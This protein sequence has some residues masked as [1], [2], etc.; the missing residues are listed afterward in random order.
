MTTFSL[1][2][3]TKLFPKRASPGLASAEVE[4][5]IHSTALK[6]Q[7]PHLRHQ[8]FRLQTPNLWLHWGSWVLLFTSELPG[9][10]L[11]QH[12]PRGASAMRRWCSLWASPGQLETF[13]RS[14]LLDTVQIPETTNPSLWVRLFRRVCKKQQRRTTTYWGCWVFRDDHKK[15]EY[16]LLYKVP[17]DRPQRVRAGHY[18][19]IAQSIS[20]NWWVKLS[21][22]RVLSICSEETICSKCSVARGLPTSWKGRKCVT[23]SCI[24]HTNTITVTVVSPLLRLGDKSGLFRWFFW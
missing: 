12:F 23:G 15:R 14:A 1:H 24:S 20:S 11:W 5:L 8:D 7:V 18:G 6:I 3:D 10:L 13:P 16:N 2:R 17:R 22:W 21:S 4:R 19:V 9:Q